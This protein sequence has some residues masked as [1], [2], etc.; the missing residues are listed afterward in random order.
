MLPFNLTLL[1]SGFFI[2]AR[3][4]NLKSEVGSFCAVAVLPILPRELDN[5][6]TTNKLHPCLRT[7]VSLSVVRQQRSPKWKVYHA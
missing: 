5:S 4:L 7:L 1:A 3:R 2:R 6:L